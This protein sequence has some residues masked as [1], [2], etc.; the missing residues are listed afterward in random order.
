MTLKMALLAPIP[1]ARVKIAMMVK[2]GAFTNI[3]SAYFRS[4][5]IDC[6]SDLFGA[7]RLHWID[8]G[9]ATRRQQTRK[10]RNRREQNGRAA[11]QRRIVG[12]NFKQLGYK[13]SPERE[14]G[15][16][17]DGETDDDRSHSLIDDK[18]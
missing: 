5:N 16:N 8:K 3:R 17:S 7:Q 6:A 1:S 10:E 12:G 11:E 4:V 13:Q 18:S 14:G 9:G 2:A 15:D